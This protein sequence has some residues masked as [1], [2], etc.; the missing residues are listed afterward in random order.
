MKRRILALLLAT[1]MTVGLFAGCG[2]S[3]EKTD[4]KQVT[5]EKKESDGT[6]T[7]AIDYMPDSLQPS[8]AGSDSL[9]WS[10]IFV[11]LR[12]NFCHRVYITP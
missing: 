6:F 7:M 11:T 9:L 2:K 10:S 5:E 12:P 4:D 8:S 3:E 1:A